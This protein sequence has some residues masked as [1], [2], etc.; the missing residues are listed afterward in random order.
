MI[1]KRHSV[2]KLRSG[3]VPMIPDKQSWPAWLKRLIG[4]F[5]PHSSG[6]ADTSPI[7]AVQSEQRVL[8]ESFAITFDATHTATAI[9][10][11]PHVPPAHA[12]AALQLPFYTGVLVIHG[13][14]GQMDEVYMD[15]TRRFL[16]ASI[17]P[18]A[19]QHRLLV[20]DGG[21]Q[22]GTA[23]VLGD[24]REAING[25]YPLVGIVPECCIS[26]PGGPPSG[27][28]AIALNAAHSH[29][30]L[31]QGAK[32]GDESELLVGLLR[33]SG[34]PGVAFIIN[35]GEIV[36]AEV[37]MHIAQ[38]NTI[39]TLEGSGRLADSLADPT[40]PERQQL[41]QF[42]RLHVVKTSEPQGCTDLLK[43][44]LHL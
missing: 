10:V 16:I 42:A 7:A 23:Q 40:S 14:A 9:R 33:A 34:R 26:Y 31:V 25:T 17:S 18:L 13:G 43:R 6:L 20:L 24:A 12:L 3:G 44:V 28:E 29:F 5:T 35:G 11:Q 2:N 41:P 39:I 4:W 37:E 19:E 36:L 1:G 30:L 21:T 8:G 15:A 32:F 38:D 27:K 22:S